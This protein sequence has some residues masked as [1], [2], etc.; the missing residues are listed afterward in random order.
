VAGRAFAS[1]LHTG[2]PQYM[3]VPMDSPTARLL[4]VKHLKSNAGKQDIRTIDAF[5]D[6]V[7][8]NYN[9]YVDTTAMLLANEAVFNEQPTAPETMMRAVTVISQLS[10][11]TNWADMLDDNRALLASVVGDKKGT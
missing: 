6:A 3:P 11:A 2:Q 4:T 7:L 10:R 1:F 8:T 5:G 9:C